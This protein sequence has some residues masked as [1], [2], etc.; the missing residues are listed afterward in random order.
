MKIDDVVGD[1]LL[2]VSVGIAAV[3][4]VIM[5]VRTLINL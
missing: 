5:V 4:T 1:V 3:F 2:Y